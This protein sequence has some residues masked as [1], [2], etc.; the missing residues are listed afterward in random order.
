[1]LGQEWADDIST[2]NRLLVALRA[3]RSRAERE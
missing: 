1:V 2:M 3:L